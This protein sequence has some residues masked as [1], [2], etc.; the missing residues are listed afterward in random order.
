ME[1]LS[2]VWMMNCRMIQMRQVSSRLTSVM[3][4]GKKSK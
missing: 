1:S 3:S 2:G 4:Y